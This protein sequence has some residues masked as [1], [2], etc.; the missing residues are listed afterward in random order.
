MLPPSPP[1]RGPKIGRNLVAM[2]TVSAMCGVLVAGLL[3][4]FVSL[5]GVTTENV[6]KGFDDLPLQ[7]QNTPVPQRSTVVDV[8]GKPIAYFYRENR[9]D[10]SLDKIAPIMQR[11][12]VAIEDY[13]FY[14]HGALDI[15]GTIRAL[16]NNVAGNNVQGGSSITQQLV[17]MILLSQANTAKQRAAATADQGFQGYARKIRELKYA[18]AYEQSHTKDQIL[19]DYL[20]MAYFGDGAYGID[21]AAHHY[22]SIKP[23]ELTV[24]ESATLAGLVQDPS[25]YNPAQYPVA[26]KDRRNTVL[27]RMAQLHIIG[28]GQ[29]QALYNKPLGLVLHDTPNGCVSTVAPFFCDYLREWL[30]REPYLGSTRGEREYHLETSG[31]TIKSTLDLRFQNAA[32][33]AVESHVY[34]TDNAIGGMAMVVP[35]SGRVRALVQSRPMGSD[36]KRGQ[37]YLN[38]VVPPKYGDARGFQAGSTFKAF[39]LAAALKKG[40]PP[41]TSFNSPD[42]MTMPGG[43]YRMCNGETNPEAWNVSSSTGSGNFNMYTGTRLSINTYYAQLEALVG[44]CPAVH[45][46]EKMGLNL[47]T[48]TDHPVPN[49]P[50]DVGPF[51]LG[52]ADTNPLTMAAAYATFPARG[53]YCQPYPVNQILDR[54]GNPVV[55]VDK[56]C[57]RVVRKAVADTINDILRGVQ[58]PGGFGYDLGHTGLNIPSAAKTGTIQNNMSVWYMGYAARLSTAAMIAG[59]NRQGHWVSLTGQT[60]GPTPVTAD[61]AFGS[62]L[63]GPMWKAAMGVVQKW[64]PDVNF[65]NPDQSKIGGKVQVVPSLGGRSIAE[66]KQA[67]LNHG[68]KPLVGSYVNSGYAAGTVAYTDPAAGSEAYQGQTVTIYPSTGYV[69]PPP[70]ANN[71]GG[72]NGGGGGGHHGGPAGPAHT[73]GGGDHGNGGPPAGPGHATGHGG[74][75]GQNGRAAQT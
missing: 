68:F 72:G 6:A 60:I 18:V 17:K 24:K 37:T 40:Y 58:E 53:K 46:A 4:P 8:H 35:G 12:I 50:V 42:S 51:T 29:A 55:T 28:A 34:P 39:V 49:N 26:A 15:K 23:S 22:F 14:E 71:G 36:Q 41:S 21:A 52:V 20:N 74:Q 7:L 66:A 5:V 27:A 44:V 38:Y 63:A 54:Y 64:L 59:A 47:P 48:T 31:L 69:P 62:T 61:I 9:Q 33:K 19:D 3:L 10:V 25:A 73:G 1:T 30:L 32:Q 67:L 13:R 2:A 70:S 43:T 45:M 75:G 65:V 56:D 16:I 11:A 57:H